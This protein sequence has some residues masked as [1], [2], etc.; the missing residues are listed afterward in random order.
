MELVL[1][2]DGASKGNPGD[3]GAGYILSRDAS[4]IARGKKYLGVTTNNVAEYMAMII[5]LEKAL[6]LGATGVIALTDSQLIVNQ[7]E[8]LYR[9]RKSHLKPLHRRCLDLIS[10][11]DTFTIRYVPSSRNRAH[12]LAEEAA[13]N[14]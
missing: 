3:A 14:R 4:I 2:T 13:E 9:V 5:G 8:G 11:L 10:D 7:I 12:R 1:E 6:S